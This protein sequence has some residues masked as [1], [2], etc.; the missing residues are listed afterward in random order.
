MVVSVLGGSYQ[1][2]VPR[3]SPDANDDEDI[4]NGDSEYG[5]D[6]EQKAL[7]EVESRE[8]FFVF[9]ENEACLLVRIAVDPHHVIRCNEDCN[10]HEKTDARDPRTLNGTQL[11]ANITHNNLISAY[12]ARTCTGSRQVVTDYIG[13]Y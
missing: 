13:M 12:R 4:Q 7:G 1:F 6:A 2:P 3:D 10:H 9:H 11:H 5:N 8:G